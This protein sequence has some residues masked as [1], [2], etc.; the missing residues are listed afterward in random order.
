M[1]GNAYT[2]HRVTYGIHGARYY[3]AVWIDGFSIPARIIVWFRGDQKIRLSID[4]AHTLLK[5]LPALL[6]DH[7]IATGDTGATTQGKA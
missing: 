1:N 5:N 7:Q 6:E 3:P 4:D 2:R